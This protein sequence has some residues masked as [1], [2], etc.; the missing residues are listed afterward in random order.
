V[1]LKLNEANNFNDLRILYSSYFG[2]IATDRPED[3]ALGPNGD[4]YITGSTISIN[5]PTSSN[6]YA[7]SCPSGPDPLEPEQCK[8][9]EAFVARFTPDLAGVVYSTY[10]GSSHKDFSM[11]IDTDSSG[12]AYITGWTEGGTLPLLNQ[13]QNYAGG[14]CL[15]FM[16]TP[17]LCIDSFVAKFNPNGSL[18]YSTYLGGKNDDFLN[19]ILV[20]SNGDTYVVGNSL[21]LDYP[22]S[23]GSLQPAV[24][25][26]GRQGI[27][28]KLGP[29]GGNAPPPGGDKR[30][31]L[32][33]IVR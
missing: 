4:I 8:D 19:D 17:R 16:G 27:L 31:Y 13:L 6:A 15:P 33:L 11:A 3:L 20:R 28:T 1:L 21:S 18:S 14:I 12:A 9:Y 26:S 29:S 30:V 7:K 23:P 2:G 5:Y 10:Y 32:P 22:T 25:G 24:P